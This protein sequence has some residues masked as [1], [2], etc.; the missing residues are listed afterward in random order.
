M[1][2]P[3][4]PSLRGPWSTHGNFL[5]LL[6]LLQPSNSARGF[7]DKTEARLAPGCVQMYS[8]VDIVKSCMPKQNSAQK[9]VVPVCNFTFDKNLLSHRRRG[10][11]IN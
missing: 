10:L 5:L 7:V 11:G 1:I 4:A 3:T 8:E 6:L 2:F 9:K